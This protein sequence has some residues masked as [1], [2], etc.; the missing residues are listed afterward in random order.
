MDAI[1]YRAQWTPSHMISVARDVL[2][3]TSTLDIVTRYPPVL[4]GWVDCHLSLPIT[5]LISDASRNAIYYSSWD[6]LAGMMASSL[7]S[8]HM[9]QC[10][11]G[12]A[13]NAKGQ[14]G[15]K[16]ALLILYNASLFNL[17]IELFATIHGRW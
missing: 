14:C 3:A 16:A 7:S 17:L 12:F 6:I 2:S 11:A 15:L 10:A 4:D 5:R 9:K 1:L 13:G 8:R